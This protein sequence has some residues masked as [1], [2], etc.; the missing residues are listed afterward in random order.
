MLR[1]LISLFL[2]TMFLLADYSKTEWGRKTVDLVDYFLH[3]PY[4]YEDKWRKLRPEIETVLNKENWEQLA[5]LMQ[6]KMIAPKES[7]KDIFIDI[8]SQ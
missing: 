4:S 8:E 1:Y 3:E 6:V 7:K 2:L 5:E